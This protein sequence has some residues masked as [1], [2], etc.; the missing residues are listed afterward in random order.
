MSFVADNKKQNVIATVRYSH[1]GER[2]KNIHMTESKSGLQHLDLGT[3]KQVYFLPEFSSR[4]VLMVAGSSGSGKS[5]FT[6]NIALQYQKRTG[7]PVFLISAK[8][9]DKT[10]DERRKSDF[11]VVPGKLK[12]S[13]IKVSDE[14]MALMTQEYIMT[15]FRDSLVV[16]DDAYFQEPGLQKKVD[17]LMTLMMRLGRSANLSLI[18]CKHQ[19]QDW[20]NRNIKSEAHA[21][22]VFPNQS[23]GK[24]ISDFLV[25]TGLNKDAI[26]R[27]LHTPDR[28]VMVKMHA[29]LFGMSSTQVFHIR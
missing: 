5:H 29:P 3:S 23:F 20:S 14:S 18:I 13:Q 8:Q 17:A 6:R 2:A 16:F 24:H 1:N 25:A 10:L 19:V 27:I 12:M 21:V 26:E 28:W 15:E 7:N 11:D 9:E 22:V 4:F